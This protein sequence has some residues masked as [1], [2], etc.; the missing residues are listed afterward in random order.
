MKKIIVVILIILAVGLIAIAGARIFT[1]EDS[2]ICVNGEWIK[3]GQPSA[4]M[5]ESGCG[6]EKKENSVL[7]EEIVVE[8]PARGAGI[9]SP[10]E[11][12][13]R[14]RGSWFFEAS[15]PARLLDDAG[16]EIARGSVEAEGE[17]MTEKMVPFKGSL[18][19]TALKSE[20]GTLVLMNDNPSGLPEN[21]K[22]IEIPVVIQKSETSKM[23]LFFGNQKLDPEVLDCS[24]VFSV[25]REIPRTEAI[26]RA[27]LEELLKGPT[28]AE[29]SA[30]YLSN[31]NSGVKVKNLTIKDGVAT[32]EFDEQLEYQVGGSCRV[33]AIRSQITETLKQFPT[34]KE[35]IISVNGRVEDALQP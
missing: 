22:K 32:A 7:S 3:H 25:E 17:W 33:V 35:V 12:S 5:P 21:E 2:W 6:E 30:G 20:N 27:A 15:F 19:F 34:V 23:K 28:E 9:K 18:I 1:G 8:S 24:K 14:A 4:A 13:G 29:K 31:I 11:I 16:E 10:L 26:G